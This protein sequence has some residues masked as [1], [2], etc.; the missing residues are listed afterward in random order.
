[1]HAPSAEEF[2]GG[3]GPC[4]CQASTLSEY[5]TPLKKRSEIR[6]CK[7]SQMRT[8][9]TYRGTCAEV[10]GTRVTLCP[11]STVFWLIFMASALRER[12]NPTPHPVSPGRPRAGTA[13][14]RAL[15]EPVP[16]LSLCGQAPAHT[17]PPPPGTFPRPPCSPQPPGQDCIG[18]QCPQRPNSGRGP[19]T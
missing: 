12:E 8:Q 10:Y 9:A 15:W 2:P 3:K 1:M 16:P 11:C 5:Y 18:A 13:S 4:S 17:S 6:Q 19:A 7:E 14:P